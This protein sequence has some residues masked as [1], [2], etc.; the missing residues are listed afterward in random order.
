MAIEISTKHFGIT[1]DPE[2]KRT[3]NGVESF[4][5]YLNEQFY[6][7]HPTIFVFVD[8]LLK[9]KTTSYI[10]MRTLT[11]EKEKMVFL[12]EQ[13]TKFVNGECATMDIV[14]C[15]GFKYSARTDL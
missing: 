11:V 13:N 2:E 10:K 8:V 12:P 15:V 5:A 4:R 7:S 1:P 3:T 14:R 6:A 9:L